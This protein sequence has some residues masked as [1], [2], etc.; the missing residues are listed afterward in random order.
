MRRIEHENI[1]EA[2]HGPAAHA[3]PPASAGAVLPGRR[4]FGTGPVGPGAGHH[5]GRAAA[6][7]GGLR[8]PGGR[9][10]AHCPDGSVG[11]GDLFPL[12]AVCIS[13]GVRLHRGGAAALCDGGLRLFS[14]LFR[15]LLHGGLRRGRRAAGPGGVRPAV[16][17]DPAL[18]FPAG[19]GLLGDVRGTGGRVL[20]ERTADCPCG[21][22]PGLL[23]P[24]R[25]LL[26]GAAGG[27]VR[28]CFCPRCCCG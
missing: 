17:G 14:V 2:A 26:S 22:R 5:G 12:S 10:S 20:W 11:P 28:S 9:G 15:V 4:P 1:D 23:G 18:L 13:A 8:P 25:R 7:S 27:C 19:G 24:V 16:H 6:V 3:A 21:L